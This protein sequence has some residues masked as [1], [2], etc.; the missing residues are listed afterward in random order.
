MDQT[1]TEVRPDDIIL[2]PDGAWCY[3]EWLEEYTWMSDDYQVLPVGSPE[4]HDFTK[5]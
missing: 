5:E 3:R 1:I 4:W 2:W